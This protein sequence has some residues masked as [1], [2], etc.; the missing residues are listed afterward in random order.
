MPLKSRHIYL[1][2]FYN[3]NCQTLVKDLNE[4]KQISDVVVSNRIVEQL[5]NI[6]DKVY[7]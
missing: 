7:T 2:T 4:L 5:S 1:D 3:I 6:T